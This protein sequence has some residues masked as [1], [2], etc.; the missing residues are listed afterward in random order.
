MK[1]WLFIY[2]ICSFGKSLNLSECQ[3]WFLKKNFK[4]AD[5]DVFQSSKLWGLG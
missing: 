4:N 1:F 2:Q 5:N 3:F